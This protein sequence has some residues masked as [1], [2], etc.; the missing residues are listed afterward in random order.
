MATTT[1]RRRKWKQTTLSNLKHDHLI[2]S[3]LQNFEKKC[4][5]AVFELIRLSVV[6]FALFRHV[7]NVWSYRNFD[8][9]TFGVGFV[10]YSA[11]PAASPQAAI[12]NKRTVYKSAWRTASVSMIE[13]LMTNLKIT[14]LTAHSTLS[15]TIIIIIYCITQTNIM[16]Q[17]KKYRYMQMVQAKS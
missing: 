15:Y 14:L 17:Y 9:K 13:K 11:K 4:Q 5:H 12:L 7:L 8:D 1:R 16:Q 10:G 3:L 2:S 6:S